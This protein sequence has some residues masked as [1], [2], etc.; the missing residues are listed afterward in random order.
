MHLRYMLIKYALRFS[1]CLN[2]TCKVLH[3]IRIIQEKKTNSEITLY[4]EYERGKMG[5]SIFRPN[6]NVEIFSY[7]CMQPGSR[8]LCIESMFDYFVYSMKF[9]FHRNKMLLKNKRKTFV[10][11]KQI[12]QIFNFHKI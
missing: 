1:P 4:L 11:K 7:Q 2:G 3:K 10:D 5:I 12:R 9:P 8:Q 6:K